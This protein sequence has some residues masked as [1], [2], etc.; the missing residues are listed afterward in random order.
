MPAS[1]TSSRRLMATLTAW[2]AL[3]APALALDLNIGY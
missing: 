2:L 1:L 3:A